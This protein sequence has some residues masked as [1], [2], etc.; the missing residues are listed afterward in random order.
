MEKREIGDEAVWSLSTAKPGNGVHQLRDDSIDT[1]WQSDGVQPH[2]I[3]IQF[4][5]KMTVQEVAL[6]LDYKLDES[7]TP[8]KISIRAGTTY[9]DLTEIKTQ[10]IV[11]PAGWITIQLTHPAPLLTDSNRDKPLRTF[12]LQIAVMGMHQNGRDTHIRQVKVYAPRQATHFGLEIPEPSS[13][14]FSSFAT[15]R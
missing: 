11:E 14:E 12:F 6:Y 7:Y 5:K 3:N 4:P 15:I 13:I 8:R 1:Y 10:T 2:L 9:H